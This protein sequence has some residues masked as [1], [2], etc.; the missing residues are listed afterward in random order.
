MYSYLSYYNIKW[1]EIM[2]DTFK[3]SKI[4]EKRKALGLSQEQLANKLGVSQKSVSKYE[5]GER[6]PSYEILVA[7]SSIF[8]VSIDYLLGNSNFESN[9]T[10]VLNN[11]IHY[12]IEKTGYKTIEIAQ[13]LGITENLLLD[14]INNKIAIPYHILVSLS[15]ICD[16]STD[17][18]LGIVKTSRLKDLNNELPFQY[19]YNI[20]RRINDL[21]NP[22]IDT[23]TYLCS[24]LSISE[25]ELYYLIEYGF[26]PHIN[27]ILKL[28][29]HF[30]VST[31][32][33]LCKIDKQDE[34]LFQ[35][36]QQLNDD[37]KDIVIGETKRFL[38]EQKL[39]A[40]ITNTQLQ[41]AK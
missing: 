1:G 4:A 16:V 6:R 32:Y 38:K 20:S 10:E 39:E 29:Q 19:N 26:I 5:C 11:T 41:A 25:T 37:N 22:D 2:D 21:R 12:W 13:L 30:N 15:K 33:L 27:V 36:F 35:S 31:D 23:D 40:A 9:N 17:C 28:A 3:G 14:Y 24:L 7:I 18:I 8:N 34:K